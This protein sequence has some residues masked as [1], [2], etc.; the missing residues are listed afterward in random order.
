M[1]R[2]VRFDDDAASQRM[3]AFRQRFLETCRSAFD[4]RYN[5]NA[6]ATWQSFKKGLLFLDQC[7]IADSPLSASLLTNRL[8]V[9]PL[10]LPEP[11]KAAFRKIFAVP[12][13]FSETRSAQ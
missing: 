9:I 11:C 5:L 2:P 13:D 10:L 7:S 12:I 1:R 6:I 8:S 4:S 3:A